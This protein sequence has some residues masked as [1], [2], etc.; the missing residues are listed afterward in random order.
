MCAGSLILVF[1]KPLVHDS[2]VCFAFA[3]GAGADLVAHHAVICVAITQSDECA[4][5]KGAK[6]L[7]HLATINRT[8]LDIFTGYTAAPPDL[9]SR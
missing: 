8:A 3:L 9:V 2:D 4:V 1:W 7:C 6:K 5:R